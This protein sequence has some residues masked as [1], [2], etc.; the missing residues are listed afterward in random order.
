MAISLFKI[1]QADFNHID[2]T[3]IHRKTAASN[4]LYK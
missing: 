4:V 3:N 2:P 1:K